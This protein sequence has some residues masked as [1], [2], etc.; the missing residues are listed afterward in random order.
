VRAT[1]VTSAEPPNI[2]AA[3][4]VIDP[5]NARAKSAGASRLEV[6]PVDP[7]PRSDSAA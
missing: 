2:V 6:M 1:C 5:A 3:L 7:Q 4:S